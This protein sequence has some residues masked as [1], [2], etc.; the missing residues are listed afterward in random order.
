MK[1]GNTTTGFEYLITDE[2]LDD[3]ELLEMLSEIDKGKEGL[4]VEVANRLFDPEQMKALK[5]HVKKTDGKVSIT[6]MV[7]EITEILQSDEATKN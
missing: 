5:S 6:G 3:W 2:V 1:Q 4:I 7:R